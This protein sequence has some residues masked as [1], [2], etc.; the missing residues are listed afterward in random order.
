MRKLLRV[1]AAALMLAPAMALAAFDA[2]GVKLG[3]N[4]LAIKK[5]FPGIHCKALEWKS[6]AADRRCDDA[7]VP[8]GGVEAR[9]TFYL[10]SDSV[11]AFDVRFDSGHVNPV[12]EFVKRRYGA[13]VSEARDKIVRKG[14]EEREIFKI[15]WE[16]GA[17]KA[18]LS[19]LS[20]GKR[21]SLSVSRGNFDDEIYRVK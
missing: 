11:K 1:V 15:L 17:D 10:K 8:F 13:P 7:K 2:N 19:S 21:A 14:K 4:E 12:A 16:Q 3:D 5:A 18:I 9:I 20:T 6:D